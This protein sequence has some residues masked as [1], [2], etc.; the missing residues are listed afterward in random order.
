MARRMRCV[1]VGCH[2]PCRG[3]RA[4]AGVRRPRYPGAAVAARHDEL[5]VRYQVTVHVAPPRRQAILAG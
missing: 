4:R 5:A 2:W 3:G 1:L